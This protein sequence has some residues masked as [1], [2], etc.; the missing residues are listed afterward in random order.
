MRDD[1][2]GLPELE[3][4]VARLGVSL[5]GYADV[6]GLFSGEWGEWPRAIS[7]ALALPVEELREVRSGGP[8]PAYYDAYLAANAAL[9]AASHEVACFVQHLGHRAKP[10]PATVS[11][12]EL[13]SDLGEALTAP[14][15]HKAVATR[16]G[17]GWIGRSG[18]LVTRTFGPRVRLATV[19]TD[20]PLPV[21]ANGR[22]SFSPI[23][24]GQCGSCR[25]CVDA[26]PAGAIQGNAWTLG[27]PRE[28]LV[29][30]AACRSMAER[31]MRERVGRDDAV[32]GVCI[33]V[34]PFSRMPSDD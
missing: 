5:H 31:L 1:F 21:A 15:H 20:M 18:L 10:Y 13:R 11:A 26:C 19:F 27:T 12:G 14:V 3:A 9:N 2:R 24:A 30:V 8:T 28:A 16:A 6:A 4:E 32:C 34:C 29:D 23:V 33:V 7:L 22:R 17:L 25:R